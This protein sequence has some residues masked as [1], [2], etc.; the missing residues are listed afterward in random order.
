MSD[1][2]VIHRVSWPDVDLAVRKIAD[3][4]TQR[5]A[6]DPFT[7]IIAVARG[8]MVPAVML[9]HRLCVPVIESVQVIG[10]DGTQRLDIASVTVTRKT[11]DRKAEDG[12]ED[13]TLVV[14]D[15]IDT[16]RTRAIVQ[17]MYP[18]SDFTSL[19]GRSLK[20]PCPLIFKPGVWIVFPWEQEP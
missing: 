1:P 17:T 9:A 14:D 2:K 19:V 7:R 8:G 10:Y 3:S 16:R 13:T 6:H 12:R 5:R 18:Q 20:D 11:P 4:I 15:I